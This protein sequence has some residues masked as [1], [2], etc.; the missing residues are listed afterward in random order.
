METTRLTATWDAHRAIARLR[1]SLGERLMFVQS[2]PCCAG[3]A[4]ICFPDGEFVIGA[5]DILLSVVDGCPFYIDSRLDEAWGHAQL[6]LDVAM[7]EPEGLSLS[8]GPGQH[9]V[10]TSSRCPAHVRTAP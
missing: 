5:H 1:A 2:R 9:F 3:S 4:L 6:T 10:T 7:G 8:A